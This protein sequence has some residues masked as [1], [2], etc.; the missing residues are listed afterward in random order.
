MGAQSSESLQD[1]YGVEGCYS[2]P[3]HRRIAGRANET[4]LCQGAGRPAILSPL[5]EPRPGRGVVDMVRP[6]E[7][8]QDIDVQQRSHGQSSSE[9]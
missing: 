2:V 1:R 5:S 8:Y 4:G 3:H 6:S 9:R 7:G